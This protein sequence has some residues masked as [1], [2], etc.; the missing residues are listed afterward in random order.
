MAAEF[1]PAQERYWSGIGQCLILKMIASLTSPFVSVELCVR[2]QIAICRSGSLCE[3]E[4]AGYLELSWG[5]P[6]SDETSDAGA[7]FGGDGSASWWRACIAASLLR[8]GLGP[9]FADF[10]S[11]QL[12]GQACVYVRVSVR[13]QAG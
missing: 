3:K 13:H 6:V 12:Q 7:S 4:I 2:S 1:S 9:I 5:P 8:Q 10:A 11:L